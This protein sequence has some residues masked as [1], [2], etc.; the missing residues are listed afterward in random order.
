MPQEI[1]RKGEPFTECVRSGPTEPHQAVL[2]SSQGAT[3]T[4]Y[5]GNDGCSGKE[6]RGGPV[7]T[8]DSGVAAFGLEPDPVKGD[9]WADD[10]L[11]K[12]LLE[13]EKAVS[14]GRCCVSGE[15]LEGTGKAASL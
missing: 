8:A 7:G 2:N 6:S 14:G 15:S 4:S 1:Y 5:P 11:A 9:G 13:Y 12:G 10:W 3:S